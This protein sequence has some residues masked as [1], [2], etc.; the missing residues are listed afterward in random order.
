MELPDVQ[1]SLPEVRINLTRVG[2][3][4]VQKLVEVARPGKRPVI[5][6]SNFDV[7]VD[8]PGSLKGANLSRNFEVIDDV[9]QQAIDGEVKVI[10]ELCSVVARKLLDRHEYAERTE[11][12]MRSQFMVRRETPVSET[13]CHEVVNVHA[14][15][16]AQRNDGSPIIR[17]SIGA[18]VTGMTAC[19]CAQNI[20]KDHAL[21]VL[22][23]LGVAEDKIEAF[24]EEVP[25]ATH[26]QRG[27]GFLCVETDDD[28]YVSLEK[29]IKI[30]KDSMSARIYELLKR[31][32]ESYVVMEAHKNARFVEDCVR[33]MAR[34]VIAQFRDLPGDSVVTIKQTNEESIHQ[35]DAYAE[36]KATIAELV[37]EMD[38]GAL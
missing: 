17:K 21:H 37:A 22:E 18:E 8:L 16:I 2:V 33:E 12:R 7:F 35:H 25:M 36:R 6:I 30:L 4:N 26:N 31:G 14:S 5:F 9:L 11:V 28:Q 23:N 1:S 10:E 34:K 32:D 19:P 20:M 3:K 29:I 24:F 15:A 13:S 38:E 27:R